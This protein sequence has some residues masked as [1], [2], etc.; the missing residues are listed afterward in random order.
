MQIL[1]LILLSSA[2][3][4][5]APATAPSDPVAAVEQRIYA[6]WD[7]HH[8][9][10]AHTRMYTEQYEGERTMARGQGE[11]TC[12][13]LR[14]GDRTLCRVDVTTVFGVKRS[15][16][17]VEMTQKVSVFLDGENQYVIQDYGAQKLAFR[18]RMNPRL[19]PLPRATFAW[20]RQDSE[21]TLLPEQTIDG[22]KVYVI[23][24]TYPPE[25][26]RHTARVLCYFLQDSG[27][28]LRVEMLGRDGKSKQVRE[29]SDFRFDEQIDPAEL[30]FRAPEGVTV[31][32][33]TTKEGRAGRDVPK[34][35]GKLTT[36]P[37]Q[38]AKPVEP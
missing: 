29:Y 7:R 27:A 26:R 4:A 18:K 25:K 2:C 1:S 8:S 28:L 35:I 24:A 19:Y 13:V 32:D 14:Q 31:R 5:Q 33:L 34:V 38:P 10:I 20:L 17:D 23:Q 12:R 36:R 37:S 6:A 21:L 11:G 9:M 15:D 3:L 16:E 22:Q 30:V